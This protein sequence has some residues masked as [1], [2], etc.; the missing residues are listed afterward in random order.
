MMGPFGRYPVVHWWHHVDAKTVATC[1][2]RRAVKQIAVPGTDQ[3]L[4]SRAPRAGW[5]ARSDRAAFFKDAVTTQAKTGRV[6]PRAVLA[7]SRYNTRSHPASALGLDWRR[8]ASSSATAL[9]QVRSMH[10][11]GLAPGFTSTG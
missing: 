2:F 8:R 11:K 4:P 7:D 6:G 5:A 3:A 10:R 9:Q 1:P